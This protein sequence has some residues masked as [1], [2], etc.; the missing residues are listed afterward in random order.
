MCY[1]RVYCGVC[2]CHNCPI[3]WY[4]Y[5]CIYTYAHT[6][7]HVFQRVRW[8]ARSVGRVGG[9]RESSVPSWWPT[10]SLWHRLPCAR[11]CGAEKQ[12][13]RR[14]CD[15]LRGCWVVEV[16][17]NRAGA[18]WYHGAIWKAREVERSERAAACSKKFGPPRLF[19]SNSRSCCQEGSKDCSGLW[20]QPVALLAVVSHVYLP[21]GQDP[22]G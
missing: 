2:V 4:T 13:K 10:F 14:C 17:R 19:G 12:V 20:L 15:A 8:R 7:L 1:I 16:C 11:A 5:I 3:L 9:G 22:D 18:H 21:D 6:Y